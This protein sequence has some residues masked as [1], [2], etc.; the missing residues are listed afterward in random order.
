M[1]DRMYVCL[2]SQNAAAIKEGEHDHADVRV[3]GHRLRTAHP[4]KMRIQGLAG[5]GERTSC[6]F[7][8][9]CGHQSR[10]PVHGL[11]AASSREK[12]CLAYVQ[13]LGITKKSPGCQRSTSQGLQEQPEEGNAERPGPHDRQCLPRR[14]GSKLLAERAVMRLGV[15]FTHTHTNAVFGE[16]LKWIPWVEAT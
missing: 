9:R 6:P 1:T 13:E 8:L 11:P 15:I 5:K 12:R 4:E 16:E 14:S 3:L 10:S 7:I 2:V